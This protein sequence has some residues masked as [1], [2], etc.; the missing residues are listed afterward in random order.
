ME[1]SQ[2]II[3]I[4]NASILDLPV[5]TGGI[6][7]SQNGNLIN[8]VVLDLQEPSAA[9]RCSYSPNVAFLNRNIELWQKEDVVFKGIFHTHY[10]GVKTLSC[11][12]RAYINEIMLSMPE[13]VNS[14]YFPVYV[15]PERQMIC[16]KAV[17]TGK[18]VCIQTEKVVIEK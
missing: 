4:I 2:S 11:G 13:G 7:G 6:L 10:F 16:Y 12:D 18:T 1:I 14:L 3:D 15:M 8:E 5:E 17:R 9:K